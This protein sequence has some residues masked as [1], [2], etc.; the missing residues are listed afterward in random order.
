MTVQNEGY[1]V[2]YES[3]FSPTGWRLAEVV[4]STEVEAI[5]AKKEM[6]EIGYSNVVSACIRYNEVA[7]VNYKRSKALST[8]EGILFTNEGEQS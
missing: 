5:K 4:Y 8:I 1:V 3:P 7:D 6:E 2:M